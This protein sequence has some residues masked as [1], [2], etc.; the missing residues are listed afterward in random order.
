VVSLRLQHEPCVFLHCLS[1]SLLMLRVHT[2]NAH[3]T[4]AM[5]DFAFVADFFDR[6][7]DFHGLS[8]P[9]FMAPL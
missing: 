2:N 9:T 5:Y 8:T 7:S 4:V 3:D 6:C 1:L